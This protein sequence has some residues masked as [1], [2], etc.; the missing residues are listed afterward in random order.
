VAVSLAGVSRDLSF[1]SRKHGPRRGGAG[2]AALVF[3]TLLVLLGLGVGFREGGGVTDLATGFLAA[4]LFLVAAPTAW[5]F[6][7]DFI[8]VTRFTVIVVGVL[9]SFP[10]WY[11]LG[12]GL[13]ESSPTWPAWIRRY[14][15]VSLTWTVT[16]LVV[17]ALVAELA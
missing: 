13:A 15:A 4:L 1:A 7:F 6:S 16:V 9:T 10:L 12:S 5:I 8:E 11:L 14:L 3:P 2:L 17:L